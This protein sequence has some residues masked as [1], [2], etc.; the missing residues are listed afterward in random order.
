MS[1]AGPTICTLYEGSYHPGVGALANSLYAAG[2][3]GTI[4]V[5]HRGSLPPWAHPVREDRG[6]RVFDCAPDLRLHFVPVT[7]ERHL[8]NFK[9]AFLRRVLG[10][11]APE[12]TQ[13]FYFDPD[14]VVRFPWSFFANW[15]DGFVALCE[16]VNSPLSDLH[17]K[18]HGW[19]RFFADQPFE[20]R[21]AMNAFANG[22]F[23]GVPRS[24]TRFLDLWD[25]LITTIGDS[26][27]D[28][29]AMGTAADFRFWFIDQDA[30][31]VATMTTDCPLSIAG[32][33]GMGFATVSG[34]VMLHAIG[35]HKP[36]QR[37]VLRRLLAGHPP[38]AID[39]EF[40]RHVETPIRIF[41]E[42][43]AASHRRLQSLASLAGRFYGR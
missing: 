18:R 14:I 20:F 27:I 4:W 34:A 38:T 2:Y 17:P 3:R 39:R 33:E 22:G 19:R 21:N 36:W 28:L 40:W 7:T 35:R 8:T 23:I 12:A 1:E 9:A 41:P 5:G 13:G 15:A 11:L 32:K 6:G 43:V 29:S 24:L 37:D 16:D 42:N 25:S 26:G 30:L 31:N 10:E